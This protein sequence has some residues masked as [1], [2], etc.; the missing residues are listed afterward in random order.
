MPR[1][2][3]SQTVK[4]GLYHSSLPETCC[5]NHTGSLKWCFDIRDGW[6]LGWCQRMAE[7]D[8]LCQSS[9]WGGFS[10][11]Q[12]STFL[13]VRIAIYVSVYIWSHFIPERLCVFC[14]SP[15]T[16]LMDSK[17]AS[18][19]FWNQMFLFS[20]SMAIVYIPARW[21]RS[22]LTKPWLMCAVLRGRQDGATSPRSIDPLWLM[23]H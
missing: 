19:S 7:V 23:H 20:S 21:G 14:V 9:T 3:Y 1:V 12:N 5:I 13:Q 11:R 22:P 2:T 17:A 10:D 15:P 16:D 6:D 8:P 18:D 4:R